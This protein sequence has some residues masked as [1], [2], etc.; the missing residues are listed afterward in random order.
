MDLVLVGPPVHEPETRVLG[1]VRDREPEGI[2]G[3]DFA[4]RVAGLLG[5]RSSQEALVRP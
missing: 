4:G 2:F 1:V 5:E 3:N